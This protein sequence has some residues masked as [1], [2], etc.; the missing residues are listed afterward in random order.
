MVAGCKSIV[1]VRHAGVKRAASAIAYRS[2]AF[3]HV[4]LV[5]SARSL[6]SV[7][8]AARHREST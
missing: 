1:T 6:S 3:S 7:G 5:N 4:A 2:Q 8:G